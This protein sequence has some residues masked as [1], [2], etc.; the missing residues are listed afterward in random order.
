[1]RLRRHKL[2]FPGDFSGWL[3]SGAGLDAVRGLLLERGPLER[4]ALDRKALTARLG[5][6]RGRAARWIAR[7]PQQTWREVTFELWCRLFLDADPSQRPA[8]SARSR[9]AK[10]SQW[11]ETAHVAA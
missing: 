9:N 2:G 6:S 11:L 7:N 10:P 8:A 1:V 4:G 5:G 3:G